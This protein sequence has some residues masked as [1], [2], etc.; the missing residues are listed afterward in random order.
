[1]SKAIINSGAILELMD[2]YGNTPLWYAV[3]NARGNYEYVELLMQNKANPN[4]LNNAGR[5]PIMFASQ[6]MDQRLIEILS[7]T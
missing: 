1:L 2:N 5:S 7:N 4:S 3:F 6:I